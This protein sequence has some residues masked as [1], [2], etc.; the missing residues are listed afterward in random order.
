MVDFKIIG[1]RIKHYRRK[2][3][4]TQNRLSEILDVSASYISQIERGVSEVSLRR[5]DEIAERIG[6]NLQSLI[7]DVNA[8]NSDFMVS[9]ISEKVR[10]LEPSEKR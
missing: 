5:L 10:G 7:A 9:E 1:S 3:G 8:N 2:A 4:M 6:T